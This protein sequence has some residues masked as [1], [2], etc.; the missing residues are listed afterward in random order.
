MA[1]NLLSKILEPLDMNSWSTSSS[2]NSQFQFKSPSTSTFDKSLMVDKYSKIDSFTPLK[3]KFNHSEFNFNSNSTPSTSNSAT[4]SYHDIKFSKHTRLKRPQ[5]T[6]ARLRPKRTNHTSKLDLLDDETLTSFPIPPPLKVQ[7]LHSSDEFLTN[8]FSMKIHS[9]DRRISYTQRNNLVNPKNTLE[10]FLIE[11]YIT[12]NEDSDLLKNSKKRVSIS[13]LKSKLYQSPLKD[14]FKLHIKLKNECVNGKR[15]LSPVSSLALTPF[16]LNSNDTQQDLANMTIIEES[17]EKL[18]IKNL[19]ADFI[20]PSK[21]FSSADQYMY[22]KNNGNGDI[23]HVTNRVTPTI[24]KHC[25]ICEKPLYELSSLLPHDKN[26]QEIVCGNCTFK[27]EEAAKLLEDYEL[28]NSFDEF[29][30]SMNGNECLDNTVEVLVEN[31]SKKLKTNQFSAH[32][33]NRLHWQLQTDSSIKKKKEYYLLDEKA[34][35]WFMEARRKLR[36]RWRVNGLLPRFL[37]GDKG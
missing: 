37:T 15:K 19:L 33:I 25:V 30:D 24:L 29:D 20:K 6:G 2:N 1:D 3:W 34:I 26:F 4:K 28:V 16:S 21:L 12:Q 22:P 23:D 9:N 14:N 10:L 32:L 36:W 7:D 27:Y 17:D 35:D 8:E 11:D 5:L 31:R 18:E 13:D